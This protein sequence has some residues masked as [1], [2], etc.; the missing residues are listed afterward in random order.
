VQAVRAIVAAGHKVVASEFSVYYAVNGE[1]VLA[2]TIDLVVRSK[3]GDLMIID[4]KTTHPDVDLGSKQQ[5]AQR[6]VGLCSAI[7]ATLWFKNSVQVHLYALL[8]AYCTGERPKRFLI[9]RVPTTVGGKVE[10]VEAA[11]MSGPAQ[12]IL[13]SLVQGAAPRVGSSSTLSAT[14]TMASGGMTARRGTAAHTD[15]VALDKVGDAV[16]SNDPYDNLLDSRMTIPPSLEQWS[17]MRFF[18]FLR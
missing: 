18:P 9:C 17:F 4:W 8:M 14:S 16:M 7:P 1:V 5:T 13:D 3:D 11:D 10:F 12:A 6:G 2:G 15:D